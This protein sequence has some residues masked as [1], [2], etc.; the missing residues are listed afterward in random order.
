ML[1][2]SSQL[3]SL[4]TR[5]HL[6]PVPLFILSLMSGCFFWGG[7]TTFSEKIDRTPYLKLAQ[8]ESQTGKYEVAIGHYEAHISNRLQSPNLPGGENPYFYKALIGD[9]YLKLDKPDEAKAAYTEALKHDVANEIV[10]DRFR[11]LARWYRE[12]KQYDLAMS[13]LSEHRSLDPLMFD[14][15]MDQLH[16][17]LI[18]NEDQNGPQL[19]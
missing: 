7:Y 13:V 10:V 6:Y 4:M 16:R 12:H 2:Q 3:T 1:S 5:K 11:Q 8:E 19:P 17:E 15:E 14:Y 18:R 9:L